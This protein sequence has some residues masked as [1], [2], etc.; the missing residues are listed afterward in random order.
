MA[1]NQ[2]SKRLLAFV[3]CDS[4]EQVP[5]QALRRQPQHHAMRDQ[6]QGQGRRSMSFSDK[7]L[8]TPEERVVR[9]HEEGK[10]TFRK[11]GVHLG[12]TPPCGLQ[13]Y[14]DP[15]A[16]LKNFAEKGADALLPLPSCVRLLR[17]PFRVTTL[18]SPSPLHQRWNPPPPPPPPRKPPPPWKP[19]PEDM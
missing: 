7:P 19:A 12:L 18:Y 16:K 8:N 3:F 6:S 15:S 17:E 10:P 13:I 11:I 2:A 5:L 4:N 14:T 9:L 1:C